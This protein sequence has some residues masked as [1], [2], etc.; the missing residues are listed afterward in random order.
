M[1]NPVCGFFM[2]MA[3]TVG[4]PLAENYRPEQRYLV[5]AP[6]GGREAAL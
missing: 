2:M 6:D 3:S 1:I 5:R 4:A